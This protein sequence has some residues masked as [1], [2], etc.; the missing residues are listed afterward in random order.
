MCLES[1]Y[2]NAPLYTHTHKKQWA[3][4]HRY[5]DEHLLILFIMNIWCPLVR[6]LVLATL[7]F[8]LSL[9]YRFNCCLLGSRWWWWWEGEDRQT[10]TTKK[11]DMDWTRKRERRVSVM[12][13]LVHVGCQCN[14]INPYNWCCCP[15]RP[16]SH[17]MH[18][19]FEWSLLIFF[20][21]Y[22][23][24][25]ALSTSKVCVTPRERSKLNVNS[26][27]FDEL[28]EWKGREGACLL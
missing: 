6:L 18:S 11:K 1:C 7:V 14:R 19:H 22:H 4:A 23:H 24:K 25:L 10:P 20:S 13:K 17:E 8:S 2:V 16:T 26:N 27:R 5:I 3:R 21:C 15:T 9:S 12:D 28:Q